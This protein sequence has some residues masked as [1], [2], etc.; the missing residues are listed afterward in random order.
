MIRECS[1][2]LQ[3]LQCLFVGHTHRLP[4]L[5]DVASRI[6]QQT[7]DKTKGTETA[8]P[9]AFPESGRAGKGERS[10]RLTV[11]FETKGFRL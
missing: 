8:L 2:T 10:I 9:Q 7:Y 5:Q 3:R 6:Y 11:L 1:F 4:R